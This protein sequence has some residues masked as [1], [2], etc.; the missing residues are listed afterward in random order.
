MSPRAYILSFSARASSEQ[1]LE[2]LRIATELGAI[3]P[4]TKDREHFLVIDY[5]PKFERFERLSS[6]W[7]NS[8]MVL[9]RPLGP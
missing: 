9:V 2:T 3:S 1:I 8:G 6:E 4:G 7:Q 5:L